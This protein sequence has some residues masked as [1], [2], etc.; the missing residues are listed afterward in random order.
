MTNKLAVLCVDSDTVALNTLSQALHQVLGLECLIEV[1]TGATEA[2]TLIDSLCDQAYEVAVVLTELLLPGLRG[3]EL[4]RQIHQRLPHTLT[5]LLTA[6]GNSEAISQAVNQGGLYRHIAKPWQADELRMTLKEA[7]QTYR[8]N[9]L[10][11]EQRAKL[12]HL[13]RLKD[14]FLANTSHELLTPPHG[15]LG[16]SNVLLRGSIGSLTAEQRESLEIIEQSAQRLHGL[17]K[18]LLDFSRL[19]HK[20]IE[21]KLCALSLREPVQVVLN[22]RQELLE[23]REIQLQNR[24]SDTLPAV[25]AD[26]NRVQQIL[27]HLIGNA[28]KFTER[29][30]VTVS[31]RLVRR[32]LNYEDCTS[33]DPSVLETVDSQTAAQ[34]CNLYVAVTVADTGTGISPEKHG[35]VFEAFQQADSS[36]TRAYE[37][38][39]LGLSITRQLVELQ[40]GEIFL[41]SGEGMGTQVIFTLPLAQETAGEQAA[42]RL[43]PSSTETLPLPIRLSA[44]MPPPRRRILVVEDD[45]RQLSLLSALLTQYDCIT[46]QNG[47]AALQYLENQPLPDLLLVDVNMPQMDGYTLTLKIRENWLANTLPILLLSARDHPTDLVT[48]LHVGANDYLRKPIQAEELLAR[49]EMHLKLKYL[50]TENHLAATAFLYAPIPILIADQ[51]AHIIGLN[52]AFTDMTGYRLSDCLGRNPG[53]FG[54]GLHERGFYQTLWRQLT[55]QGTW[56]GQVKNRHKQGGILSVALHIHAV[57][58]RRGKLTHYLAY[59]QLTATP[60]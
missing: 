33:L 22:L 43:R 6:P 39:G 50:E 11:D 15:L 60:T 48:G 5:I 32:D 23:G 25:W 55:E 41:L 14:Q 26:P 53:M 34:S 47:E 3:D 56:Q 30:S 46:M 29:G 17:V 10:L 40:N 9:R 13:D 19:Q 49:I 58:D 54:A 7:L 20:R 1:A 57:A 31:A 42:E 18:N 59:Y 36:R 8:H 27:H 38:A 51:Q 35:Q 52:Q 44:D 2:L 24:V 45:W 12:Q 4:L 37:G 28:I 16:L 21:P